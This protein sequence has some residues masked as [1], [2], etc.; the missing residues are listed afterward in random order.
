MASTHDSAH[1]VMRL[2]PA[3]YRRL[4]GSHRMLIGMFAIV[5]V[6]SAGLIALTT[7][8]ISL[9]LGQRP[10]A[11]VTDIVWAVFGGALFAIFGAG[12][13]PA[14]R[15]SLGLTEDIRLLEAGSAAH[16]LMRRLMTE[17][18]GTYMHSVWVANLAEA[19]A[20]KIGADA[21]VARVGSY[22]HDIGKLSRPCFFFENQ[23]AGV[24]PHDEA[25]PSLSSMIITAHVGDG[26][27]LA[28]EYGLPEKV[29]RIIGEHHG[30]MLVR[31][32]YHK[33]AEQ[34]A[35]VYE[36]DFRYQSHHPRSPEA[37]LV[38]LADGCEASVRSLSDP[39]ADQISTAVR[40]VFEDR[41]EDHQLDDAGLSDAQLDKLA[42]VFTRMLASMYHARC[43]YPARK[44]EGNECKC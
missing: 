14:F 10:D 32:F 25:K 18:P 8:L 1:G 21:L 3:R 16:P 34:D 2:V 39:T 5:G 31:Y 12:L 15:D 29:V 44:T 41:N 38:M 17:A 23:E 36:S 30:D 28:R 7:A 27:D 37:A 33:A 9:L 35:S 24:N 43:A 20:Q 42:E 13:L 4:P 40:H 11:V 19:G 6:I 26:M 22:Y